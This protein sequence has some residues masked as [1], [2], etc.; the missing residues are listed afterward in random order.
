MLFQKPSDSGE[1][2]SITFAEVFPRELEEIKN[3][4]V[5]R[6]IPNR[7]RPLAIDLAGISFSGGGIRSATFN[8]GVIQ[9]LAESNLLALIDYL[10]T[11]SGGGYI[12]SWLSSWAYYVSAQSGSDK[13]HIAEIERKLNARAQHISDSVEPSQI[14]FLRRYS[15]YLTPRLGM[16]SGDTLA[17]IG[18]YARNL[19]LNLIILIA[20]LSSLLLVPRAIGHRVRCWC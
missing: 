18:T 19:F 2:D 12:G 10:S 16:L 7:R 9:A 13:N 11:V 4:R 6:E 3:A 15:N 17:F 5:K 1:G 14:Q 20:A 8:L